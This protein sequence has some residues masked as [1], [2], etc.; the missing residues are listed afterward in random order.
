MAEPYSVYESEWAVYKIGKVV[1]NCDLG[2]RYGIFC[3]RKRQ[4]GLSGFRI[5][6][7]VQGGVLYSGPRRAQ[8]VLDAFAD[9]RG[10]RFYGVQDK[11]PIIEGGYVFP[12][13]LIGDE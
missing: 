8:D 1:F 2:R 3:A 11:V 12:P 6:K 7:D 9:D 4:R 5:C 10:W 13:Q